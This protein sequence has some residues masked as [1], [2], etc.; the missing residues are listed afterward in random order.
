MH[1]ASLLAII[2][3]AGIGI[4]CIKAIIFGKNYN[5]YTYPCDLM[6]GGSS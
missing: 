6:L 2:F 4:S 3:M 5:N 1:Y